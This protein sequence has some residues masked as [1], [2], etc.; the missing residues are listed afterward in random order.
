MS[1][2]SDRVPLRLSQEQIL[3]AIRRLHAGDL[4]VWLPLS[5]DPTDNETAR[6][7]NAHIRQMNQFAGELTYLSREMGTR[8]RLGGQ[9]EVPGA[10]GTWRE[11]VV[12]VNMMSANLTT[13]LRAMFFHIARVADAD[14]SQDVSANMSGELLEAEQVLTALS[15]QLAALHRELIR[16]AEAQV[17][18]ADLG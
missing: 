7:F 3:G 9:M 8:G 16:L 12:D 6:L 15:D 18:R 10:E 17:R 4:T 5:E 11:L 14:F 1:P 13:N 2:P